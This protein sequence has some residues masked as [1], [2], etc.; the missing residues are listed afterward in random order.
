MTLSS[1]IP[2]SLQIIN[3]RVTFRDAPIHLLE[4]FAFIDIDYAHKKFIENCSIRECVIIQTCNRVEIFAAGL[5]PDVN[6]LLKVWG[7]I[8]GLTID[9]FANTV[10]IAKD[11]DVVLHLLRL[12]S[13]LDSLVIGEDQI[14][15]QVKRAF[16][17]A[18]KHHYAGSSLSVM[19]DRAVKLGSRVRTSTSLNKGSISIG[20]IAVNLAEDHL[21]NLKSKRIMLIGTGEGATL[22]A[23]SLKKRDISFLVTSRT[24]QRAKA[25]A[26]TV[27]GEPTPF[28]KALEILHE[29]DLIFVSTTAPYYLITY[30]R[31]VKAMSK[32]ENGMMI[33]DL[34]NP[35]TV[36]E[37]VA[38]LRK[39]KLINMDQIAEIVE[40]NRHSRKNE[41]SSAEKLIDIEMNSV[42]NMYKRKRA[43]PIVV[44]IFKNVDAIRDSELKKAYS[45]LGKK[46]GP[47]ESKIVEKLSY[48]IV[49]GILSS[50]MNNLRKELEECEE[51]EEDFMKF[52][53]KLFNY[54]NK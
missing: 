34:S 31:V 38:Q 4:K 29:V 52:I 27:G 18:S 10:E 40:N 3:A 13:G 44:S 2:Q 22:V 41:I 37:R 33:L 39:I 20:S 53:L 25:F 26:D 11:R 17:F 28:E 16:D 54:E 7:S 48:A 30:D 51:N 42:Y 23:K 43:E 1:T 12:A 36:E 15:G 24:F 35:R 50:P 14:L 46:I 49:E 47:E 21:D 6:K 19:F 9:E 32:R 5:A 45:I 8:V